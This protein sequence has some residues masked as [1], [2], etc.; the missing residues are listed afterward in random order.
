MRAFGGM[1]SFRLLAGEEAAVRTCGRT[2]LFTLNASGFR[3]LGFRG[4]FLFQLRSVVSVSGH[5]GGRRAVPV[6]GRFHGP[7]GSFL[8]DGMVFPLLRLACWPW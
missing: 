4:R 8:L 5:G 2:R 6:T 3:R 1:V 7:T